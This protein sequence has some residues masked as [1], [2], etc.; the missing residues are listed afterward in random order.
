[1]KSFNR[2]SALSIVIAFFLSPDNPQ[3]QTPDSAL[4]ESSSK[5][6]FS[7]AEFPQKTAEFTITVFEDG[8]PVPENTPVALSIN[9]GSVEG[10]TLFK[11]EESGN[12]TG[13]GVFYF[14]T[15][16]E[17]RITVDYI[18]DYTPRGFRS[19]QDQYI[20]SSLAFIWEKHDEQNELKYYSWS[21]LVVAVNIPNPE[22]EQSAQLVA[23]IPLK[24]ESVTPVLLGPSYGIVTT[25]S[26]NN[27]EYIFTAS[28]V[29]P[30]KAELKFVIYDGMDNPVP[31]GTP[32]GIRLNHPG[33][34]PSDQVIKEPQEGGFSDYILIAGENGEL[35]IDYFAPLM[36]PP[37]F[38]DWYNRIFKDLNYSEDA[39][40]EYYKMPWWE[41]EEGFGDIGYA[42]IK[43]ISGVSQDFFDPNNL[44]LS[45][46]T[47][48]I[49]VAQSVPPV[50]VGSNK[51]SF[52]TISKENDK[53]VFTS[54]LHAESAEV[55]ISVE[56]SRGRSVPEGTPIAINLQSIGLV[57]IT[58]KVTGKGVFLVEG[59]GGDKT[60]FLRM[61]NRGEAQLTYH[62]PY[63]NVAPK[64]LFNNQTFTYEEIYSGIEMKAWAAAFDCGNP[65]QFPGQ[66]FWNIP[67]ESELTPEDLSN[68]PIVIGPDY[69]EVTM[70]P[71]TIKAGS[72][73]TNIEAKIFDSRGIPVPSNTNVVIIPSKGNVP[74][75]PL[76]LRL[77]SGENGEAFGTYKSNTR[78]IG[79]SMTQEKISIYTPNNVGDPDGWL[80]GEGIFFTEGGAV[81][82][83]THKY[84]QYLLGLSITETIKGLNPL[85]AYSSMKR[86]K[87]RVDNVGQKYR[88]LLDNIG[89]GNLSQSDYDDYQNAWIDVQS[90]FHKLVQDVPG[91]SITGTGGSI[92]VG[93]LL[94]ELS[95]NGVRRALLNTAR[96]DILGKSL[97]KSMAY[98]V[99]VFV[100]Q[101]FFSNPKIMGAP[102]ITDNPKPFFFNI[103]LDL[104]SDFYSLPAASGVFELYGT[105]FK[106]QASD[107]L[108]DLGVLQV[109]DQA[110]LIENMLP[111]DISEFG[112]GAQGS[113]SHGLIEITEIDES[114]NTIKG[115]VL[116]FVSSAISDDF[117]LIVDQEFGIERDTLEW[118]KDTRLIFQD[119]TVLETD[120]FF[121]GSA[122]T[123]SPFIEESEI[124]IDQS[125]V[126]GS[127]DTDS[128]IQNITFNKAAFV[129][130]VDS[131]LAV[132]HSAFQYDEDLSVWNAIPGFSKQG[133]TL[134]IPVDKTS[135]IGLGQAS[136]AINEP[137]FLASIN[138]TTLEKGA[139]FITAVMASDNED[140]MLTISVSSDTNAVQASL[141]GSI[142]T[143][144]LNDDF[145]GVAT[146]TINVFDGFNTSSTSFRV[147]VNSINQPPFIAALSD[148]SAAA[149]E[150]FMRIIIASD[151]D[152]DGIS[153][154]AETDTSALVATFSNMILTITPDPAFIGESTIEVTVSDGELSASTSFVLSVQQ[155]TGTE[156]IDGMPT[157]I[158]LLQNYP[159][160]FNPTTNISFG[161]PEAGEISLEVFDILGRKVATLIDRELTQAGRYTAVFDASSLSSGMYIYRLSSSKKVLTKKLLLI[162]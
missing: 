115:G 25:K 2:F 63:A 126:F 135:I 8:N 94:K 151:P 37:P 123:P 30:E 57:G 5:Y 80:L 118:F 24:K 119:S 100:Q 158:E 72:I 95:A 81:N 10:S 121:F 13:G 96:T 136:M 161:I 17:G 159:N 19:F 73:V 27:D 48:D 21:S 122:L 55:F 78:P 82:N 130:I 99:D 92:N 76:A 65:C 51:V 64:S 105:E 150:T 83:A 52:G 79:Q 74:D 36:V 149:G 67:F 45:I 40:W 143:L 112:L 15:N 71:K 86:F 88:K 91:T 35:V 146:I 87:E 113:I 34:I 142:L 23:N 18:P 109:G 125:Y 44:L 104:T 139:T 147:F 26:K 110:P 29:S 145:S 148:T 42:A 124:N 22:N 6:V 31:A 144:V 68:V 129:E 3:A 12:N 66:V 102:F 56:D 84:G 46:N 75:A 16:A 60:A 141:E 1:M 70:K 20:D 28:G 137:P 120:N 138:D 77:T 7:S 154:T 53:Y 69:A 117:E 59:F 114:S 14:K 11:V 4:W 58:G 108:I 38:T 160:P 127:F 93:G 111:P 49:D 155:L 85:K 41:A 47:L 39:A 32:F 61:D 131:A 54:A 106:L 90:S 98:S 101:Q 50:L 140:D 62:A 153:L 103:D 107:S 33:T 132:N 162:K 43:E 156:E 157:E 134:T 133:D 128:S 89:T 9:Y 152:G 97:K 116:L